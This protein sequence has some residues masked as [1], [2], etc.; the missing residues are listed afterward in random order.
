MKVSNTHS[1]ES[2]NLDLTSDIAIVE[3]H[4]DQNTVSRSA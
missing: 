2:S 3:Y 4:L 1:R